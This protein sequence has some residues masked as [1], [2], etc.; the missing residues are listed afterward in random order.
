M[1]TQILGTRSQWQLN[2]VQWHVIFVGPQ[3]GTC[4]MSPF[5]C[6]EFW[7]GLYIFTQ[8]LHP[9]FKIICILYH[10]YNYCQTL[11]TMRF[12]NY[13]KCLL[14][15]RSV[16]SA[17]VIDLFNY[18][19][20]ITME[21]KLSMVSVPLHLCM[22]MTTVNIQKLHRNWKRLTFCFTETRVWHF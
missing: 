12:F 10:K 17:K 16:V 21:K 9:C 3:Y 20:I 15:D 14:K 19:L 2:C 4:F 7:G 1:D 8:F 5:W 18:L 6:L 22:L 13:F 11:Q